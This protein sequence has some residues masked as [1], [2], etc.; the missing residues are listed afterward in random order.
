VPRRRPV[1]ELRLRI[2]VPRSKRVLSATIGQATITPEGETFDLTGRRG[3]V[4]LRVFVRA[5]P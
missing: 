2:R 3:R 5:R 1:G 4:Q